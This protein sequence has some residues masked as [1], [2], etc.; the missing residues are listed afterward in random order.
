MFFQQGVEIEPKKNQ[1]RVR[2]EEKRKEKEKSNLKRRKVPG[3][4]DD[5]RRRRKLEL[6]DGALDPEIGGRRDRRWL[7]FLERNL[8]GLL[9]FFGVRRRCLVHH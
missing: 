5:G 8:R 3:F 4:A 7:G 6:A 2:D 1:R 9:D